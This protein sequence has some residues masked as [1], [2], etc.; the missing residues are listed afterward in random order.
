MIGKEDNIL[1]SIVVPV[2]NVEM[3]LH[4]CIDSI[5]NQ[6]YTKFEVILIDDG[7][8]DSSGGICDEY[9]KQFSQIRVIHSK[10]NG[11]SVARNI[12]IKEAKGKWILFSDSDDWL[13]KETLEKANQIIRKNKCDVVQFGFRYVYPTS[14]VNM[15]PQIDKSENLKKLHFC[16]MVIKRDFLVKNE[17]LFPEGITFAED[18]FFKYVLYSYKPE[19]FYDSFVS[20]NYFV[21]TTSVMQNISYKH[22]MDEVEVIKKAENIKS[23]Y[24]NNLIYQKIVSKEKLLFTLNNVKLWRSTFKDLNFYH[25]FLLG[26]KHMI[27]CIIFFLGFGDKIKKRGLINE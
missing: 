13:E 1:F 16:T 22:I 5:L 7:S 2:Y 26:P 25:I 21:N 11:V 18:W 19:I 3:Y 8:T 4:R 12:G 14:V 27:K 20:Y 9:E 6:T 10:N 23:C 15:Q 17:I 24:K